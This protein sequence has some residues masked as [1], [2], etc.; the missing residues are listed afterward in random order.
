MKTTSSRARALAC[1]LLATTAFC[2]LAAPPAAAQNPPPAYRTLDSNGVDLTHGDFVMALV[3][4]S[5]G[6]GEGALTLVRDG[7]W[8]SGHNG[9]VWDSI[10]LSEASGSR[11]VSFGRRAEYF[12]G[13]SSL[14]GNGSTLTLSGDHYIHR[15]AHGATTVF[16]RRDPDCTPTSS[17]SCQW[18]PVSITSPDGRETFLGWDQWIVCPDVPIDQEVHCRV[19]SVRLGGIANSRGY[20]I[21][22]TYAAGGSGGSGGPSLD[23]FRRTRA[24]FYNLV[25]GS[26][27]QAGVSYAYPSAGVTEVTDTGGLVWRVTGSASFVTAIRR[28]GATGDTTTIGYGSGRVSSVARDGVTTNY[29][30]VVD[31]ST[32]T[33]TVTRPVPGGAGPVTT[34]LSDLNI[35]RPTSVTDPLGHTTAYEYDAF[36]RLTRATAPE[37]NYV[38]Y[39]HDG[40]GNVIETRV[41]AKAGS[42]LPDRIETASFPPDC[43]NPV[44]CNQPAS[45]TDAL[46]RTTDFTYDPDHGGI[47]TA[48]GPEPTPNA[49]RPQIRYA[50]TQV[51]G[52]GEYRL[53]G[54]SQCRTT[55][56]CAGG[57][58]EVSS[59]FD[60]DGNGNV[61]RISEGNAALTAATDLRYDGVGNLLTVDGPLAG[62]SDTTRFRYNAAREPVGAIGPDPDGPGAG[63]KPRATRNTIDP[64]TGL[65][66]RIE[67]GNVDSQS[68]AH[69]AAFAPAQA[70]E[71]EYDDHGRPVKSRLV[72]AAGA[73]YAIA[74]TSYDAL[75]RIDCVAQRMDL[76]D[77]GS[78]LP[79]ACTPT[80]PAGG[81][82]PDRIVRTGYDAAGRPTRVTAGVGSGAPVDVVRTAY[83]DNGLVETL[84][85][86]EG[87]RTTYA[88]DGHDRL[89]RTYFPV[90]AQ[91]ALASSTGDYEELGYDPKGN[92][93]SFRNRADETIGYGYD[94]LDRLTSKNLPGS[95]PDVAYA[96]DLLGN[97]T[98]AA[99]S[100]QTLAFTWDALGRERSQTDGSR[101][102]FSEYDL[103]GR[104]TRIT[105]PDGF[106]VDQDYLVTGE[107]TRIRENG[108]TSGIGVLASY[109]Y[110]QLGRRDRL[111]FGNGEV[112][113]YHYDPVSRLDELKLD[114]G[115]TASDVTF[116]YAYNPAWQI[117][118]RTA[119]SDLYAWTGHG[120][121]TTATTAD[122][123]NRIA[124]WN[125]PL[126]YDAKGN[127]TSDG[128]RTYSYDSENK[129]TASGTAV[130]RYDPLGR[131]AGAGS[132]PAI[133]YEN[134]VDGLI[135][136]RL[137][138]NAGV[139]FRHVFGPGTDEPIV[140]YNG[141]GTS[142]RRFL[143]ADE[144]GSIVAVTNA[145]AGLLAINRYDEYGRT[146]TTSSTFLG[147]F[148]YTGQRYFSSTGLYYYKNRFYHPSAG[149]RFMQPDPIGYEAGMNLYAYV[150]GD[151]IN[152]T[153]P[154]GLD[155][156]SI[157]VGGSVTVTSETEGT[158]TAGRF[159]NACFNADGGGH[160]PTGYFDG[161]SGGGGAGG[162]SVASLPL[163]LVP[164][165]TIPNSAE[166]TSR[167]VNQALSEAYG[168]G[169]G[170]MSTPLSSEFARLEAIPDVSRGGWR[171]STSVHAAYA[172]ELP[173]PSMSGYVVKVYI[174]DRDLGGRNTVAITSP[175]NSATHVLE[176]GVN[177]LTGHVGNAERAV[178]YLRSKQPCR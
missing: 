10:M 8:H 136:E 24:D 29:S 137:V 30:R 127:M 159:Y 59:S 114:L 167:A 92:V 38:H 69:W 48:T 128:T 23:W 21:V 172:W 130:F 91:G 117:A 156:Y 118:G 18:L 148:L 5:I 64:A 3:E 129:Q 145:S 74:Q 149:G 9:H 71:M 132:P 31:G 144:R 139:S 111:V 53:T 122:G 61:V 90:P 113:D 20:S 39:E 134:Y 72:S 66:T 14:Q 63:L 65:T 157:H 178:A 58:D 103:A 1:A 60:Y 42:N 75:G 94:A 47:E 55:A 46:G 89:H 26:S 160:G 151:P 106:F 150:G 27:P 34:I 112:T 125:T 107:M 37:G 146:Q 96:F 138:N 133:H 164:P 33:M 115:G 120:N 85:D 43:A 49:V 88:Y 79:D 175:I 6:S 143:H 174:N 93:V 35:G 36:G 22:F 41:V 153:D 126:A 16:G 121:G 13:T 169:S 45:V 170:P 119:T 166:T 165:A 177:Y 176:Y 154:W 142:D 82:G 102:Y 104:R 83:T 109:E 173:V 108:A 73:P 28:P 99:T 52:G 155:C 12:T 131:L 84:T 76:D 77:F 57:A 141:P 44:T 17:T 163:C 97:M 101:S 4:G 116:T 123:L 40:R 19:D 87:N 110:D 140:W 98:S 152:W 15:S 100:S 54:I 11:S 32:A 105:H 168:R 162:D 68:D 2:G 51:A 62:D 25:A 67:Q 56:S 86:G 161:A 124:S 95:E 78:A 158:V 80:S 135:A 50:Y 70:V 147:R 7:A 171:Q 81:E